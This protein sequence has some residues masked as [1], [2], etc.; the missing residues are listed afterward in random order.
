[1]AGRTLPQVSALGFDTEPLESK[2][3]N[4]ISAHER[5]DLGFREPGI[6]AD[7]CCNFLGVRESRIRVGIVGLEGDQL[8]PDP[9]AIREP[10]F[11]IEDAAYDS[12]F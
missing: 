2:C 4:S 7:L 11:I 6:Y 3:A 5:V 9:V 1:M 10:R 8:H 12:V